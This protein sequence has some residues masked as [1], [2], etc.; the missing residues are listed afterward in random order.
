MTSFNNSDASPPLQTWAIHIS[1]ARALLAQG[2]RSF[3]SDDLWLSCY[4]FAHR[5]RGASP[6]QA[7]GGLFRVNLLA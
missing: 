7:R 6:P 2:M 5:P 3:A 1:I 4:I